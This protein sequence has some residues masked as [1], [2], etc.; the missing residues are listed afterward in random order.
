LLKTS[1]VLSPAYGEKI[2]NQM[3]NYALRHIKNNSQ[4]KI[5]TI[6]IERKSNENQL[7]LLSKYGFEIFE[8]NHI[9]G[10][11]FSERD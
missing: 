7:N 2:A 10:L 8:T 4:L 11:K 5:N 6:V 1:L 3:I 9:L